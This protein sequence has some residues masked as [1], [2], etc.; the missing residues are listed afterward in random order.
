MQN[1]EIF[2]APDLCV[3]VLSDVS[4]ERDTNAKRS[5][6]ARNGVREYW[7]VDPDSKTVTIYQLNID[8]TRP[9][10]VLTEADWLT[11][12]QLPDFKFSASEL[13]QR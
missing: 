3:E 9:F 2:G 7:I 10:A 11:S 6:Y 5:I 13:F 4:R 8:A 1:A 12:V